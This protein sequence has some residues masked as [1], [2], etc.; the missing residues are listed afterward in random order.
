MHSLQENEYFSGK[1]IFRNGCEL[2]NSNLYVISYGN[3]ICYW[4][5]KKMWMERVEYTMYTARLSKLW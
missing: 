3:G 4:I 5:V 1:S 2:Y